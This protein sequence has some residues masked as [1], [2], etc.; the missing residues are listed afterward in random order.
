MTAERQ[1]R[2]AALQRA[3]IRGTAANHVATIASLATGFVLTPILV[4]ELGAEQFGLWALVGSII[5]YGRLLDLGMASALTKYVAEYRATGWL[6]RLRALIATALVLYVALC[7]ITIAAAGL[8]VWSLPVDEWLPTREVSVHWLLFL[9]GC[10]VAVSIPSAASGAVLRGLHRSDAASWLSTAGLVLW[11][12][13][14]AGIL[15]AGG[16]IVAIVAAQIPVTILTQLLSVFVIDRLAPELRFA[17]ARPNAALF[18]TVTAYS[19]SMFLVNVAGRLQARTDEI[20]VCAVLS[21]AAVTPYAIARRLSGVA[22]LATTQFVRVLLP[23]ASELSSATDR[24]HLQDLFLVSTRLTL[25]MFAPL[26]CILALLAGPLLEAWVGESFADAAAVVVVLTIA[27]LFDA[28]LMPAGAI[29]QGMNRHR[30]L[31][32]MAVASGVTNLALSVV[33]ASQ[34]GIMGVAV[35]TLIPTVFECTVMV[36]PYAM[37]VVGITPKQLVMQAIW[38]ALVPTIPMAIAL[39]ALE[40][41]VRPTSL[42]TVASLA[43]AGMLVY[44]AAYLR[45]GASPLELAAC[46]N[47]MGGILRRFA[48]IRGD[49]TVKAA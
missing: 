36:M 23:V 5:A 39:Y 48:D 30:P 1:N 33:L 15:A 28:F 42:P 29:L 44:A 27:S 14:V 7:G 17:R 49:A 6:D 13:A 41:A 38:P 43:L 12:A 21:V 31:A 16:G 37:R 47:A 11:I 18:R 10:S 45:L 26:G 4:H 9:T 3:V 34:L 19:W 8:L 25:A 22:H 20:V 2:T 24:G 32:I 46:R 35:G 40:R